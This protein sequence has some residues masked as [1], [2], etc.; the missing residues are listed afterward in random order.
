MFTCC[1]IHIYVQVKFNLRISCFEIYHENVYDL[2][3][4]PKDR[5]TLT[6]RYVEGI[7]IYIYIVMWIYECIYVDIDFFVYAFAHTYMYPNILIYLQGA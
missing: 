5:T 2:F 7:N 3:S 6:V 4:D 1:N